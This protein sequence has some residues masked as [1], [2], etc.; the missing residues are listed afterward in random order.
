M[1]NSHYLLVRGIGTRTSVS[2]LPVTNAAS[3]MLGK[4]RLRKKL[5]ITRDALNL[6][7]ERRDLKKSREA[8]GA[9]KKQK[10]KNCEANKRIQ[11]KEGLDRYSV[12]GN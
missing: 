5:W 2:L 3:K 6:C 12:Q 10:K 4:E 1:R 11:C 7:Y 9:K 8:E